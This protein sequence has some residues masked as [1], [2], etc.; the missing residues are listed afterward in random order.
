MRRMAAIVGLALVLLPGCGSAG[1]PAHSSSFQAEVSGA[2]ESIG[3][4]VEGRE[5]ARQSK[6]LLGIAYRCFNSD[7]PSENCRRPAEKHLGLQAKSKRLLALVN[8]SQ[9]DQR[10]REVAKRQIE[11]EGL[12]GHGCKQTGSGWQ[13]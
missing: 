7:V 5:A 12:A 2:M 10:A 1:Q 8:F 13:C 9:Y 11:A 4:Y 6:R 3:D